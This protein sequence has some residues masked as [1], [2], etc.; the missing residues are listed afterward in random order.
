MFYA[1]ANCG[2]QGAGRWPGLATTNRFIVVAMEV[3]CSGVK[4][5]RKANIDALGYRRPNDEP[6]VAAVVRAIEDCPGQC[7]DPRRVYA[8]GIS[9]G[10]NMTADI[11]CDKHNSALFR[12]YLIDSSSLATWH[13][14]PNCP[15]TNAGFFVMLAISNYSSVDRGLY[16]NTDPHPHLDVHAFAT[17]V[18]HRLRCRGPVQHSQL[19]TAIVYSYSAPCAFATRGVA[20]QSLGVINGGHGWG[21][22]DSDPGAPPNGCPGMSVPPGLG[23]DRK[24]QTGGLYI[25]GTFWRQVARGRS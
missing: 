3:S 25:E 7:V 14:T 1:G 10:A 24:P 19:G 15:T 11:M 2:Y 4:N 13:G 22:Q 5:W 16:Y 20:I 21:C 8:V 9:S 6:Y 23:P 17:W 12:G 18:A